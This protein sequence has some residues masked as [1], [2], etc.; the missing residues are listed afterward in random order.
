VN[1]G[2]TASLATA[3]EYVRGHGDVLDRARFAASAGQP[4]EGAPVAPRVAQN[5]DGGWAAYWSEG[6]STLDGTCLQLFLLHG[7]PAGLLAADVPAALDFLVRAQ[8]ADGSWSEGPST[9]TPDWL[10]PGSPGARAYL[11][12]NCAATL[13]DYGAAPEAVAKAAE[14]LEWSVDPHGRLPAPTVA[15]WLAARVLRTQGRIMVV[16]R[17]LDVVGRGF[18]DFDAEELAWFG[19]CTRPGDRWNRR[20]A[21][22]LTALQNPDGSW[23]DRDG[24]PSSATLTVTAARVLLAAASAEQSEQSGQP[25]YAAESDPGAPAPA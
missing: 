6:A 18:E 9:L 2:I 12:A 4:V 11:T 14:T 16:R 24:G 23:S 5:P 7:I 19:A 21:G 13:A 15:H 8:A 20:I 25:P 17:L 10:L 3:W 22:R 1:E